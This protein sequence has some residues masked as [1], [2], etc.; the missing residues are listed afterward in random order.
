MCGSH[1]TV[2]WVLWILCFVG[3]CHGNGIWWSQVQVLHVAGIVFNNVFVDVRFVKCIPIDNMVPVLVEDR[4]RIDVFHLVQCILPYL[5]K[6][7]FIV[8]HNSMLENNFLSSYILINCG[9][10]QVQCQQQ[11]KYSTYAAKHTRTCF[12]PLFLIQDLLLKNYTI[13]IPPFFVAA[14]IVFLF[15]QK[16]YFTRPNIPTAWFL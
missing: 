1:D 7:L 15:G 3:C 11:H 2:W 6:R 12:L 4:L 9:L 13:L 10:T 14:C 8:N 16:M 5:K